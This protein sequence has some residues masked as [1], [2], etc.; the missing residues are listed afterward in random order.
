MRKTKFI[1]FSIIFFTILIFVLSS[2]A[3]NNEYDDSH[4]ISGSLYNDIFYIP[5]YKYYNPYGG[6]IYVKRAPNKADMMIRFGKR[7]KPF[8]ELGSDA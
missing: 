6:K 2:Y 8:D 5:N 7:F 1:T 3:K 4:S